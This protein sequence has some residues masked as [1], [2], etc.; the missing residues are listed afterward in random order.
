[1]NSIPLTN[2]IAELHQLLNALLVG[3]VL[4]PI[5]ET[6]RVEHEV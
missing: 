4:L 1:M 5:L 6:D 3:M 2:L